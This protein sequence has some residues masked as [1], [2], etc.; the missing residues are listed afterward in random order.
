MKHGF[1]SAA[2]KKFANTYWI[3]PITT[4]IVG[5]A[6]F[7]SV[8]LQ[9]FPAPYYLG[10]TLPYVVAANIVIIVYQIAFIRQMALKTALSS[11]LPVGLAYLWFVQT[12]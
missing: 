10:L 8:F 7:I 6:A 3:P 11:I 1:I 5:G 4:A 2:V 9:L 12:A